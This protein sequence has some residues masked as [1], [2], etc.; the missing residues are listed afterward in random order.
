M[1]VVE[2]G[3]IVRIVRK[4]RTSA[5]PDETLELGLERLV[6]GFDAAG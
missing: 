6:S 3:E 4:E 5:V 2:S 1:G